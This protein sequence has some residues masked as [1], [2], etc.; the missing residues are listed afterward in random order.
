MADFIYEKKENIARLIINRPDKRNALN[1]EVLEGLSTGLERAAADPEV[2]AVILSSVGEKAFTAGFDLKESMEH[3]ITDIV[4]RRLDSKVDVALLMKFWDFNK[5]IISAVQGYCVGAG[6]IL[7]LLG[8]LIVSS[9]DAVY[10]QLETKLGFVPEVPIEMW[11]L[12]FN[13]MTEWLFMG[14]YYSAQEMYQMGVVN[15]IVP[16]AE[17]ET[18][19]L[20]IAGEVA[21]LP[22]YSMQ[23]MKESIHKCYDIQ[24][25]RDTANLSTE[26]FNLARTHMQLTQ[27]GEFKNTMQKGGLRAALD[28]RYN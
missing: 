10:G 25:F 4:E 7:S 11:K 6:V 3:D 1:G 14:K 12:P 26:M 13:K 9:D 23:I 22:A 20:E 18:K 24:G 15:F 28:Q 8:D 27:M 16:Y 19:A 17:L 2:K 5:P 21:K